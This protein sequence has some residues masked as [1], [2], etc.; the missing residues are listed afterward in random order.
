MDEA[1]ITPVVSP[2]DEHEHELEIR[3]ED[4][5]LT[6]SLDGQTVFSGDFTGNFEKVFKR[7]IE[8]WGAE[9]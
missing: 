3:C 4:D 6:F 7:A 2:Q 8:I 9:E 1:I 5:V